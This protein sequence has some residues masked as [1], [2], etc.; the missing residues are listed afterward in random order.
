MTAKIK[1]N[2]ASGGGSFSLQAPAS[3]SNNRV[4][5]LPDIA[6]GT[7]LTNQSSLDSTK[8]SPAIS[9][10]L[11]MADQ[12]RYTAEFTLTNSHSHFGVTNNWERPDTDLGISSNPLGTGMTQSGGIFSFPS[13]GYYFITFQA[14]CAPP[15]D[16]CEAYA[17]IRT[18][19]N[20]SSYS[21]ASQAFF[22]IANQCTPNYQ[23]LYLSYTARVTD[24]SNQK[25]QFRVQNSG[26]SVVWY[27]N[28]NANRIAATFLKL[29][30]I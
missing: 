3:S 4:I 15:N 30:D 25:I 17:F 27:G 11:A 16:S 6:D 10:G 26:L 1:L 24:T 12:W 19:T 7:L 20:N 8:L 28:T 2:A 23:C 21:N 9:G 22:T 13:T 5:T 14:N 29:G 18:T